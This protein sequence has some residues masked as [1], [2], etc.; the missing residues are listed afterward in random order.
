MKC[1]VCGNVK[2]EDGAA[3]CPVCQAPLADAGAPLNFDD[4]DLLE[5]QYKTFVQSKMLVQEHKII[6]LKR[7]NARLM[8]LFALVLAFVLVKSCA[9]KTALPP[10]DRLAFVKDSLQKEVDNYKL[11]YGKL[12]EDVAKEVHFIEQNETPS[13]LAL[14]Y[15]G[16]SRLFGVIMKDNQ[17]SNDKR[18]MP[19]DSIVIRKTLKPDFIY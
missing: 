8:V 18:L 16:D 6:R 14:K 12:L 17:I 10:S 9:K 5:S 13:S 15:Y 2:I 3:E 11:L 4:Q 7:S 19:G 1:P